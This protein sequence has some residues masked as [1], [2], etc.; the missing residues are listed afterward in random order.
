MGKLITKLEDNFI[1]KYFG[2]SNSLNDNELINAGKSQNLGL[3]GL[4][5]IFRKPKEDFKTFCTRIVNDIHLRNA[6]VHLS[7]FVLDSIFITDHNITPYIYPGQIRLLRAYVKYKNPVSS[8]K[9]K[10]AVQNYQYYNRIV[11][12]DILRIQIG[13]SYFYISLSW[14]PTVRIN[15]KAAKCVNTVGSL[16]LLGFSGTANN[17]TIY[18]GKDEVENGKTIFSYEKIL[19]SCNMNNTS[20]LAQD[21]TYNNNKGIG[22]IEEINLE[23]FNYF[24]PA[25]RKTPDLSNADKKAIQNAAYVICEAIRFIDIERTVF[26]YLVAKNQEAAS[27]PVQPDYIFNNWAKNGYKVPVPSKMSEVNFILTKTALVDDVYK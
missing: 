10:G 11:S 4:Y 15:E 14:N 2:F 19:K 27:I 22:Q 3:N 23:V 20:Q 7:S 13:E 24:N 9:P 8:N 25:F 12:D 6:C 18:C 26:Q 1:N 21:F 16:Y 5:E 17:S